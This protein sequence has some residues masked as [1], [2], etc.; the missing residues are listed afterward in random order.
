MIHYHEK[1]RI[2]DRVSVPRSDCF[3]E[4]V[5]AISFRLEDAESSAGDKDF[6]NAAMFFMHINELKKAS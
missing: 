2:V 5:D 1:C 6:M 3:K 4:A